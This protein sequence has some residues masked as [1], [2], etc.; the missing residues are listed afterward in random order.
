MAGGCPRVGGGEGVEVDLDPHVSG[1]LLQGEA[2]PVILGVEAV[3][4]FPVGRNAVGWAFKIDSGGRNVAHSA[5][6][7][8][9]VDDAALGSEGA[10]LFDHAAV[11]GVPVEGIAGPGHAAVEGLLGGEDGDRNRGLVV[12]DLAG[13]NHGV[14]TAAN[15]ATGAL[16][17]WTGPRVGLTF[18]GGSAGLTDSYSFQW[19]SMNLP[20]SGLLRLNGPAGTGSL[21]SVELA[22]VTGAPSF[23]PGSTYTMQV[24]GFFNPNG[25][26]SLSGI[27]E[28]GLGG[29]A[30]VAAN[31]A[32]PVTPSGVTWFGVTG[33]AP[34]LNWDSFEMGT[35]SQLGVEVPPAVTGDTFAAWRAANFVGADA[36]NDAISGPSAMPAG[37]GVANLL[38]YA[39][40]FEPLT[41]VTSRDLTTV[42]LGDGTLEITYRERRGAT[43]IEYLPQASAALASWSAEGVVELVREI[44]PDQADFDLVTVRATLPSGAERGFLRVLVREVD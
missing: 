34:V 27:L 8:L 30:E 36:E 4:P 29:V 12:N 16:P 39:F 37:D 22:S 43:D 24:N 35:P 32:N 2:D 18:L 17:E 11:V 20:G 25:S 26:L 41:T 1:F 6:L 40:G 3:G 13:G 44:D 38:K 23:A 15:S 10:D 42:H 31:I 19:E 21:A 7:G 33:R 28:D 9:A 14:F 5:H